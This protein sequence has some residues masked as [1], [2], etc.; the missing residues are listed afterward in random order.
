MLSEFRSRLVA[1]GME[2][3][4]DDGGCV[5]RRL[6]AET[7]ISPPTAVTPHTGP[8]PGVSGQQ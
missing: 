8:A 1:G 2:T 5:R 7:Q 6:P 4:L 3:A